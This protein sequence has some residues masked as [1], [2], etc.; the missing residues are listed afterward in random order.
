MT[1]DISQLDPDQR[2]A[3]ELM[4]AGSNVWLTGRAGSG[5]STVVEH[6]REICQRKTAFLAPTGLAALHIGGSTIHRFFGFPAAFLPAGHVHFPRP[7]RQRTIEAT[8]TIVVDEVSMVRA[9]LFQAMAETLGAL[10]LPGHAGEPFGGRQIIVCG[11][12]CQLPPVVSSWIERFELNRSFGGVFAFKNPV[13][14]MAFFRTAWLRQAHRQA[15]EREF[16][17]ALDAIRIGWRSSEEALE[18]VRWLNRNVAIARAPRDCTVLCTTRKRASAINAVR[19]AELK[20]APCA[21]DA[22]ISGLFDLKACPADSR[23][24]LRVGSRIM[25]LANGC[26]EE[27]TEYVNGDAGVVT[28]IEPEQPAVDVL[29]DDGRRLEV[30]PHTWLEQEYRAVE[31]PETGEEVLDLVT[32]ASLK[33]IPLKLAYAITIHKAQGMSMLRVHVDIGAGTFAS[34]QLYVA[35]SRCRT[36]AGLSLERPV[37][38]CNVRLDPEVREFHRRVLSEDSRDDV[39]LVPEGSTV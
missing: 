21:F 33:Q 27:G 29:L 30:K 18:A 6:F 17:D 34:G 16:V 19:D 12:F 31:D 13:W 35:L 32:V 28:G 25:L 23:L 39:L 3:L 22:T 10:P 1:L 37:H 2:H 4:L 8:Q 36:L 7:D 20:S 38:L 5:K 24:E 15:T 9:D 14:Q 11:D 26:T